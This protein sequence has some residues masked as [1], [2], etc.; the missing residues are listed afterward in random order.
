MTYLGI[1]ITVSYQ[2]K[3][4]NLMD[5]VL[6]W[7]NLFKNFFLYMQEATMAVLSWKNGNSSTRK[8]MSLK[9]IASIM[10]AVIDICTTVML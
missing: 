2:K 1:L 9:E 8:L 3:K 4:K 7:Q 5:W 10:F 6:K